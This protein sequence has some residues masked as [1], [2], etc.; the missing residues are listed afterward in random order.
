[1]MRDQSR[2]KYVMR[3]VGLGCDY[4]PVPLILRSKNASF[5]Q[6]CFHRTYGNGLLIE[7]T[8]W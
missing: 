5:E 4:V 2:K 8:E 1:M 6:R 3:H 7:R